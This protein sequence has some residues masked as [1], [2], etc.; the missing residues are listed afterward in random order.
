VVQKGQGE[1]RGQRPLRRDNASRAPDGIPTVSRRPVRPSPQPPTDP[2]HGVTPHPRAAGEQNSVA[3]VSTGGR[4]GTGWSQKRRPAGTP[5]DRLTE[6]RHRG[7]ERDASKSR[8]HGHGCPCTAGGRDPHPLEARP[9]DGVHAATA[10]LPRLASWG[11]QRGPHAPTP[12]DAIPV[13]TAPRRPEGDAREPRQ[14]DRGRRGGEGTDA[15]PKTR[16]G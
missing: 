4:W 16:V 2:R 11:G 15:T 9:T 12:A 5:R 8:R 6:T 1:T 10:Q 7:R 3:Q 14:E 13:G